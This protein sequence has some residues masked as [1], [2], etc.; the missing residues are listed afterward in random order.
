MRSIINKIKRKGLN[1]L[2]LNSIL[3]ILTFFC[4]Y[5]SIYDNRGIKDVFKVY[6][7]VHTIADLEKCYN[8]NYYIRIY[9][10]NVYSTN[11]GYYIDEQLRA[12]YIDIDLEGYSL[13]TVA[14]NDLAEELFNENNTI[15]YIDGFITYL[16]DSE[17]HSGIVEKIKVD[18]LKTFGDEYT[19]E[20]I[21]NMVLPIQVNSYQNVKFD[22]ISIICIFTCI[23]AILIYFIIKGIYM[24]IKPTNYKYYSKIENKDLLKDE[25]QDKIIYENSKVCLTPNYIIS[26]SF[27]KVIIK[28]NKSLVWIFQRITKYYGVNMHKCYVLNF[29]DS[30]SIIIDLKDEQILNQFKSDILFGYSKENLNKYRKIVEQNK[31]EIH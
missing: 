29:I 6:C 20:D 27:G 23:C 14:K 25:Y 1:L 8:E 4:I 2:I 15:T 5:I 11:Y 31:R 13:I 28:E 12:Y 26:F 22:N 16:D 21:D 3:L 17:H 19:K 24:L 18:Y 30:D 9:F 7:E 10:D